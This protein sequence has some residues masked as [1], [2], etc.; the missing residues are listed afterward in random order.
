MAMESS[1]AFSVLAVGIGLL[2]LSQIVMAL[3][4]SCDVAVEDWAA[5]MESV[6]SIAKIAGWMQ[7]FGLICCFVG[8]YMAIQEVRRPAER[9]Q[10]SQPGVSR[11]AE[12]KRVS[13]QEALAE[14]I[15]VGC[16]EGFREKGTKSPCCGEQMV[17]LEHLLRYWCA[18]CGK[19]FREKW[20]KS[21]CCSE[22]TVRS[23]KK[24]D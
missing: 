7:T 5:C 10:V 1:S 15:C 4:P 9:K 8:I 19:R 22:P 16:G 24:G 12:R 17:R 3:A 2:L 20:T 13:Q 11:P 23:K 6:A 18:S 21:P 14:F